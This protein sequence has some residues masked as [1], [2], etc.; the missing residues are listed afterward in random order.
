[1]FLKKVV[2][3]LMVGIA[4]IFLF[5]GIL[6]ATESGS[7][8]SGSVQ[9]GY[10]I[11]KVN[12]EDRSLKFTVYRGDYIKFVLPENSAAS[13]GEF[14]TLKQ[15]K[16]VT[17]DVKSTAYFKMKKPG[18]FPFVIG[19]IQGEVTVINFQKVNYQELT[20]QQADEFIKTRSPVILDV[21]TRF[22]YH[23]GHLENSVL[24]P[25]QELQ[26]RIG[27]LKDHTQDPIL[28]YCATGNRST[29]ASKILIDAGFYKI[30]NLRRGIVDWAR[31]RFPVVK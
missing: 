25:V 7:A 5:T 9:D 19:S 14:P 4:G 1:M 10:R 17:D 21:R 6:Q 20:A 26:A 8:V 11:L 29:V 31:N 24:I 27:E 16:P 22:E 3:F 23:K 15:Q 28:I 2:S 30:L 12:P 13:A 18:T